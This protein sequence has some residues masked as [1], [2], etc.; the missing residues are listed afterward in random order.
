MTPTPPPA[1]EL[2]AAAEI[3]RQQLRVPAYNLAAVAELARFVAVERRELR[4][5]TEQHQAVV[6]ALGCFLGECLVQTYGAEWAA[7]PGGAT[8][9][10]LAGQ[11]FF[12][13]FYL[14]ERHLNQGE[15]ASVLAF[16]QSVPA[17]LAARAAPR[18]G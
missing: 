16:F 10:G 4:P 15:E 5:K 13:P 14:V 12:N 3:V 2:A 9:V 17:R 1:A 6:T 11:L 18:K 7:G 8:G